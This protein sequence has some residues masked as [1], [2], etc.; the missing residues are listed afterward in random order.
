MLGWSARARI[1]KDG[2]NRFH[3]SYLSQRKT[4]EITGKMIDVCGLAKL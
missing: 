1:V 3:F 2:A 4:A